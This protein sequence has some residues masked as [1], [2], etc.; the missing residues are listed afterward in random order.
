MTEL[1]DERLENIRELFEELSETKKIDNKTKELIQDFL[2]QMD[3][4]EKYIEKSS[5]ITYKNFRAYKEHKVKI[6]IY[7]NSDKISKDLAIVLDSSFNG[8]KKIMEV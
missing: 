7:N 5:G 2:E 4:N 3:N 6:L 1:I 8:L